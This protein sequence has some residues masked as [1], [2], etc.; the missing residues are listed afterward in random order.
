MYVFA[1]LFGGVYRVVTHP[2]VVPVVLGIAATSR[3]SASRDA[4]LV[5]LLAKV[6][7]RSLN[8][9]FHVY[10]AIVHTPS[11]SG[12]VL[13]PSGSFSQSECC[14]T[15]GENRSKKKSSHKKN[16]HQDNEN[17]DHDNDNENRNYDENHENDHRDQENH[18]DYRQ[19]AHTSKRLRSHKSRKFRKFSNRQLQVTKPLVVSPMVGSISESSS[20]MKDTT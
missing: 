2:I 17:R 16:F 20:L 6:I 3:P 19:Q 13:T 15:I 7:R 8:F 11:L 4:A 1:G 18:E 9:C 10:K 12:E 5:L 14:I